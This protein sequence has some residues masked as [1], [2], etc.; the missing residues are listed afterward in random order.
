VDVVF[1]ATT[2][3]YLEGEAL[4]EL[5][6]YGHPRDHRPDRP[7]IMVGLLMLERALLGGR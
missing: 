5:V 3:V 2:S 4:G 6:R 7:Q 1:F